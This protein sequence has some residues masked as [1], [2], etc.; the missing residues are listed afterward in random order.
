MKNI[1]SSSMKMNTQSRKA[2]VVCALAVCAV[3]LVCAICPASAATLP[4]IADNP[5]SMIVTDYKCVPAVLMP[6]DTGTVAVTLTNNGGTTA[7]INKAVIQDSEGIEMT[8]TDYYNDFGGVAPGNSI[9]IVMPIKAGTKTGTFYPV[10]YVDFNRGMTYLKQP[11]AVTID[12]AG[13]DIVKTDVPDRLSATGSEYITVT[14]AN[15]MNTDLSSVSLTA[16]GN[17]V[18]CKEGSVFVGTIPA[19]ESRPASLT[20][21]TSD[22]ADVKLVVSFSNGDNKH[23]KT[24][25]IPAGA[26]TTQ[27]ASNPDLVFANL[28]VIEGDNY[29]TLKADINNMGF[30]T[31]N[32]V[33]ITTL[34]GS[35]I[36]TYPMYPIG[37]LDA[38]DL[39][40]FELTFD[41]SIKDNLTLVIT[42]KNDSGES[43]T[44]YYTLNVANHIQTEPVDY[45]PVVVLIVFVVIIAVVVAVVVIRKKKAEK[46]N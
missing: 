14:L 22:A 37:N 41:K 12:D 9:T 26:Q 28:R 20:V 10:F 24:I 4:S 3:L 38:D 23:T 36:G 34:E 25:T 39:A 17:G 18:S 11:L 43:V 19:G 45:T 15:R 6:G 33:R 7:S 35:D 40:G 5:A 2:G 21:K 13:I 42:Y 46:K 32:S 8:V 27:S 16:E 29:N 44:E 1:Y 30:T 31:A